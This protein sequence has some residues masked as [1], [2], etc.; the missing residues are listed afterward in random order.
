[1][2][3]SPGGVIRRPDLVVLSGATLLVALG[4][5]VPSTWRHT[6]FRTNGHDL[7]IFDQAVWALSRL[8]APATTIR[9][10]P[11]PNL[12]GDHFH[13]IVMLLAPWYWIFGSPLVLL[14]AQAALFAGVVP[15]GFLVARQFEIPRWPAVILS[16][17]LGIHPGFTTAM[18]AEFHEIAFAPALLLTAVLLADRGHGRWY[19]LVLVL[20]LLTK[21]S[22]GLYAA[23]FGITL[24]L[25][26]QWRVGVA[27]LILGVGYFYSVTHFVM[28]RL[29]GQE[30]LYW[31]I[32]PELG[33]S[34][35][36][37]IEHVIRHPLASSSFSYRLRRS[38]APSTSCSRPSRI[39]RSCHGPCG[40][41][42]AEYILLDP[43]TATWPLTPA[44]VGALQGQL[45]S[46]GWHL[47]WRQES[48]TVFQR[49]PDSRTPPTPPLWD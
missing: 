11:L 8:E 41:R 16:V 48:T 36:Q 20:F 35:W 28:P 30:Y 46:L 22:M 10:I 17:A 4:H 9:L 2:V 45:P 19:W 44:E 25:R 32:Y 27:T 38:V 49:S 6:H 21:E 23:L 26:R 5:A 18:L 37:M 43:R 29:A 12:F 15:L 34:T 7:G 39:C 14:I 40:V 31:R 33:G 24:M 47:L 42:D 13:P 1:M 3:I